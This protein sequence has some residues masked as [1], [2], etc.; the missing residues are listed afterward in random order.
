MTA[1]PF[2]PFRNGHDWIL[3]APL[4]FRIQTATHTD[5]IVVPPGFVTDFASVPRGFYKQIPQLGSHILPAV[6]HDY[7]YWSQACQKHESDAIFWRAME[8]QGEVYGRAMLE[9]GAVQN[10]GARAWYR[11]ATDR[12]EG[13]PRIIP[14]DSSG[15]PTA[16]LRQPLPIETWPEYRRWLRS[17]GV[18]PQHEPPVVKTKQ[19]CFVLPT[20]ENRQSTS[21]GRH[22]KKSDPA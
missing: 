16:P 2:L 21:V 11:N 3:L 18:L 17:Q 6:V 7:L 5:S 9:A 1:V 20:L 19:L 22:N 14:F 15:R 13:L 8:E 12:G 4:V 10:F